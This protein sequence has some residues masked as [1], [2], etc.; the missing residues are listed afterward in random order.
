MM[1]METPQANFR[2]PVKK[3]NTR[4]QRKMEKLASGQAP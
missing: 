3:R 2:Q 4:I 1:K